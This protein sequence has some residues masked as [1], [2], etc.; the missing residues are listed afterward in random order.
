[1][2]RSRIESL[3]ATNAPF[4]S[5]APRAGTILI[6]ESFLRHEVPLNS[7]RQKRVSVS[8]NFALR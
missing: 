5:V 6:W 2:N 1:M 4:I 3:F 8:F 7:A